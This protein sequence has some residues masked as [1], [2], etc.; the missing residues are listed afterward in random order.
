[1]NIIDISWPL[2]PE[3]TAY[4]DKKTFTII[5]TKQFEKD[6]VR[7]SL[8]T[9]SSHAGTHIDAPSHFLKDGITSEQLSLQTFCGNCIVID[10]MQVKECITKNDLENI[11]LPTSAIILFKTS[12]S[13]LNPTTPFNPQFIYLAQD[14]AHYLAE[15]KIKA[16]G[17]DYLGIERNQPAHETHRLLLENNIGIIEGLRLASVQPGDYQLICLP[18]AAQGLDGIPA[19]AVLI[20]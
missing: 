9:M 2:S 8:I 17:I 13:S 14:T 12:N 16:V 5:P 7:E 19:R 4:K 1:M 6:G 10:L 3:M 20:D 18:L 11:S 15:Q